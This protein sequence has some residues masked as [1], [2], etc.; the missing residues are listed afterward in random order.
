MIMSVLLNPER[1]LR[2]RSHILDRA[3][4]HGAQA[5]GNA[6]G[7]GGPSAQY[8]AVGMK[9]SRKARRA[10]RERHRD[11]RAQQC[12]GKRYFRHIDHDSLPETHCVEI[13][14]IAPNGALV[15]RAAVGIIEN[16]FGDSALG[17]P[18]EIVDA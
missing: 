8:L 6:A 11:G 3:Y 7:G 4:R 12:R 14:G 18:A 15:I 10:D 16:R 1:L 2:R 9:Q 5:K 17:E 13:G